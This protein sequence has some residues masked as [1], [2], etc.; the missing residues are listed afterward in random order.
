MNWEQSKRLLTGSIVAL[1][2]AKDNFKKICHVAVIAARPLEGLNH[3][4]PEI[5]IFFAA[6]DEIRIDPQE[7]WLMVE[8]RNGFYEGHR[9]TLQSLQMLAK[10]TYETQPRQEI[11]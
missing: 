1:T 10:E 11:T 5:D 8:S 9:H 4:P 2:S 6:P 3:N 7:E